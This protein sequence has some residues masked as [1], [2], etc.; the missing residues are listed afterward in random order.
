[1]GSPD[2]G[3]NEISLGRKSFREL[4]LVV[5]QQSLICHDY[6]S[7]VQSQHFQ[8]G[9]RTFHRSSANETDWGQLNLD[10]HG[11]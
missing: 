6:Q 3:G 11:L 10:L 8:N 9:P 5:V 7:F 1:M 2:G 4:F